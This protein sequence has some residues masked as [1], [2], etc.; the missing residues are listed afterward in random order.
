MTMGAK[1]EKIAYAFIVAMFV[2]VQLAC[3]TLE[4]S[5]NMKWNVKSILVCLGISVAFVFFVFL[6][7][8]LL[9]KIKIVFW[10]APEK[11]F[12]TKESKV[13]I[14]NKAFF[15]ISWLF[16]FLCWIPVFLAYY[17]GI[18]AYDSYVQ[19][20]QIMEGAYNNH[21]PLIHTF[22]IAAFMKIGEAIGNMNLGVAMY[23]ILQ[24]LCLSAT[25]SSGICLLA[26]K[27]VKRFWL[28]LIMVYCGLCPANSYMAISMTKDVY[29]TIFV[30]L[31]GYILLH[32]LNGEKHHILWDIIFVGVAS[33]MMLFRNNGKYAVLVFAGFSVVLF[34]ADYLILRKKKETSGK[35]EFKKKRKR[36][37]LILGETIV[38]LVLSS[39]LLSGFDRV[40][41]SQAGDKR[42]MLSIPIQQVARC[43]VYHGGLDMVETDDNSISESDKNIINEFILYN[44]YTQYD[45]L[46]SDPVKRCTNTS[47]ILNKPQ[48][49][50]RM[51]VGLALAYPEEYINAF[52]A[53]NGGYLSVWDESHSQVNLYE[54]VKG[55]GY[56]Q[57]RWEESVINQ[58]GIYKDSKIP[59]L[60]EALDKFASG[61]GYL[62]IPVVRSL[63]APGLYI[64][65]YIFMGVWAFFHRDHKYQLP[66][67]F[68]AGYYLTLLFGPTVQLRYLY[69]VMLLLPFICLYVWYSKKSES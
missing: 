48:E 4:L 21:H 26:K 16:I 69:P 13:R 27:G 54:D 57:T 62:D 5:G 10:D 64:W 24:M 58:A 37:L 56:L 52:L 9:K 39:V 35:E 61:N 23:T 50:V 51:Y 3:R 63:I 8:S 30:L 15:F 67:F 20:G 40:V 6:V 17:P 42:E 53:V 28:W 19:I 22:M 2:F 66:F 68:V 31:F 18:L 65:C 47:V 29:F 44:G 34:V 59:K 32:L 60:Y 49:F 41:S 12:R 43:M 38:A 36:I 7:A 55:L 25:M 33:L 11:V 1:R 14:S 45:P 46:I